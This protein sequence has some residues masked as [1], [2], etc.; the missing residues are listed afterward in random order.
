MNRIM[1]F[2][3]YVIAFVDVVVGLCAF[4]VGTFTGFVQGMLGCVVFFQAYRGVDE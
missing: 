1:K 4:F 3:G 2:V